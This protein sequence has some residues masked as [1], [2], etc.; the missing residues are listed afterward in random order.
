MSLIQEPLEAARPEL[1]GIFRSPP[2]RELFFQSGRLAIFG[3]SYHI[4]GQGV[5]N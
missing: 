1:K 3:G 5:K 4:L 2:L